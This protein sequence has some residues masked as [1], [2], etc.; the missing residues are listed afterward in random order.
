MS[1]TKFV[2]GDWNGLMKANLP[3]PPAQEH[4]TVTPTLTIWPLHIQHI[5]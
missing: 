4:S 5:Y 3:P 2:D 1:I